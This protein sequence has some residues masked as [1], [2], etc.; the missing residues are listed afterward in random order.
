MKRITVLVVACGI[1]IN[2]GGALA[3]DGPLLERGQQLFESVKL[4]TSGKSCTSCHQG[5]KNL[6]GAE[7]STEEQLADTINTCIAGPLKGKQL[8]PES[9]DMKSMVLYLKSLAG[10]GK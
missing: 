4:G 2:A 1:F 8:D 10:S 5:G 7:T 3:A 6:K 9:A